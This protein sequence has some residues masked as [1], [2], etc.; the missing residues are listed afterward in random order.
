M[1]SIIVLIALAVSGCSWGQADDTTSVDGTVGPQ[2]PQGEKGEKGDRGD[3]GPQG[4]QGIPGTSTGIVGP[5]GPQGPQGIQGPQGPKGDTGATG[6][7]GP[8]GVPGMQGPQGI[9][10]V[11]GTNGVNGAPGATGPQGPQGPAGTSSFSIHVLDKDGNELGLP[12]PWRGSNG[13]A[14]TAI[15]M[16]RD[17]PSATF[18]EGW[19]IPEVSPG[20]IYYSGGNC[21]GTPMAKTAVAASYGPVLYTNYLYWVPG[22]A[23]MYKKVGS[24]SSPALSLRNGGICTN[25]NTVQQTFDVLADSGFTLQIE[26]TKPW[27]VVAQ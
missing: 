16:H 25:A 4:P 23:I 14:E 21:T 20:T 26:T 24:A 17:N 18:P 2:G 12:I 27:T 5:Q 7:Q 9:P 13:V 11:N 3:T 6:L 10:G 15:L 19:V 8:Q 1:K 22:F